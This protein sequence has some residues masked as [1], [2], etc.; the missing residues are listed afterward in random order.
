MQRQHDEAAASGA[1]GLTVEERVASLEER[2]A[3]LEGKRVAQIER[4]A[5]AV[6]GPGWEKEPQG[7]QHRAGDDGT[8]AET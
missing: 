6:A 5:L 4:W 2:L 7:H 1:G 8:P 3:E